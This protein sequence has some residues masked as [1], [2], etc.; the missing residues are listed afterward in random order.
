MTKATATPRL[1]SFLG[2]TYIVVG[3]V[4]STIAIRGS[5]TILFFWFPALCGGGSLILAGM[6]T[7]V[8]PAWLSVGLVTVG[9]AAGGLATAWTIVGPILSMTSIWLTM[10]R[11]SP[12][13]A[14]A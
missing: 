11:P 7:V 5:D 13:P 9:S 10:S 4:E 14:K 3:I 6:F 8:R 12:G 1:G 2:L